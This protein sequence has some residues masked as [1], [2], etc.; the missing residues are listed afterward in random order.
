MPQP[1]CYIGKRRLEKAMA[2]VK[3]AHP[4]VAF[5]VRWLPFQLHPTAPQEG[6]NKLQAYND[7]FGCLQKE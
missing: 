1:W 2:A 7:K 6:V 3:A 5:S 4:D